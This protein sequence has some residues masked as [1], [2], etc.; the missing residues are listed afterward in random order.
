LMTNPQRVDRRCPYSRVGRHPT[1]VGSRR[2]CKCS[3]PWTV[4]A[5]IPHEFAMS[6]VHWTALGAARPRLCAEQERIAR[7]RAV[8]VSVDNALDGC[9]ATCSAV[10]DEERQEM[11]LGGMCTRGFRRFVAVIDE[12]AGIVRGELRIEPA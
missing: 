12:G 10:S 9:I 3:L 2:N 4:N 11:L 8:F 5:N 1:S 7:Q 6:R